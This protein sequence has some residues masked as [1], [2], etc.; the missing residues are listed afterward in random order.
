M[1]KNRKIELL[2]IVEST[3]KKLEHYESQSFIGFLASSS[4]TF[5]LSG[6]SKE[7]Y[8]KLLYFSIKQAEQVINGGKAGNEGYKRFIEQELRI[9]KS[10]E[11]IEMCNKDFSKMNMEEFAYIFGWLRRTVT[12]ENIGNSKF[13]DKRKQNHH[14]AKKT[15]SGESW[16][17]GNNV[18]DK[19]FKK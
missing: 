7:E 3:K 8:T 9:V 16:T 1:D 10:G 4:K 15:Y 6:K 11:K 17:G 2:N 14:Y 18:F 19:I 12:Q 5:Y 13:Q